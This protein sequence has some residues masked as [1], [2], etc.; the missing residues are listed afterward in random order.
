MPSRRRRNLLLLAQQQTGIAGAY[1]RPINFIKYDNHNL[2]EPHF[3]SLPD[4]HESDMTTGQISA[5]NAFFANC[6]P[7]TGADSLIVDMDTPTALTGID[8]V[9]M[10]LYHIVL[11]NAS[12]G[13]TD[14]TWVENGANSTAKAAADGMCALAA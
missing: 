8:G 14:E 2:G 6:V 5:L 13:T 4:L 7:S 1:Q 3:S 10:G 12:G 9:P 11:V